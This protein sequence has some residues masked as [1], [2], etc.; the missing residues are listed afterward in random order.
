MRAAKILLDNPEFSM[1]YEHMEVQLTEALVGGN[2]EDADTN[3]R[4]VKALHSFKQTIEN[5]SHG[6]SS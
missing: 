6:N 2:V 4:N 1:L 5:L 3:L